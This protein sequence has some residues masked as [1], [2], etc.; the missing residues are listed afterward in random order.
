MACLAS[1]LLAFVA[2]RDGRKEEGCVSLFQNS[3]LQC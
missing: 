3:H 2:E 1:S